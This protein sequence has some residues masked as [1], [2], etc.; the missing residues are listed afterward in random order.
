MAA[1]AAALWQGCGSPYSY[2]CRETRSCPCECTSVPPLGFT[3]P[4]LLY[5]GSELSAP[6]CPPLSAPAK[7]YEG[8]ADLDVPY[9]CPACRCSEPTCGLPSVLRASDAPLCQGP[10][11][12]AFGAPTGWDGSCVAATAV[13]DE[14][15]ASLVI[16]PV[17]A[18]ACEP[19]EPEPVPRRSARDGFI[20][21][22]KTLARACKGDPIAVDDEDVFGD[23]DEPV[24]PAGEKC[25]PAPEPPPPG[26]RQCIMYLGGGE[27]VC[28][29]DYPLMHV[30]YRDFEDTR[31]C[32]PCACTPTGESSCSASVSAYADDACT[33]AFASHAVGTEAG[34]C[35]DVMEGV[36]LKSMSATWTT[37]RP[38]TCETSGGELLGEATP[39]HP[40]TFCC[41]PLPAPPR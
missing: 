22:W 4:V 31:E 19:I 37:H 36:A 40:S 1:C 18:T 35:V 6:E 39:T 30:F 23:T 28:P 9:E 29:D 17:T 16:A 20:S 14:R 11:F 13:P 41:Q 21:P 27:P 32:T 34:L 8:H 2:D 24:C 15:L 5:I 38:G 3:D 10:T 26:F 33:D 7:V 25:W 12:T